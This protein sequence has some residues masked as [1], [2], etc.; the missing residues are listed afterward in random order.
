MAID[1]IQGA[2]RAALKRMKATAP[3]TA[4]VPATRIYGQSA[5]SEPTW[6][7]IKWG[8]PTALP[9]RATCLDG[10]DI[11][12]SVHGFAGPRKS[13]GRIVETAEDHASRIGAAIA[14]SL[15][16]HYG[17]VP[18]GKAR[19]QWTRTQ[20]LIDGSEADAYHVIVNFR[21]RCSTNIG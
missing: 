1:S 14:A 4:L 17:D 15:D 12:G 7:F 10:A 8:A 6:P 20:L 11:T 13:G 16:G 18:G 19:F 9:R 3:L 5:G 2:R 21:I